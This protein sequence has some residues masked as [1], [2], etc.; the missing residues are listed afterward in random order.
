VAGNTTGGLAKTNSLLLGL[1]LNHQWDDC[2][3]ATTFASSVDDSE[4]VAFVM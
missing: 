4:A 3:I 2:L 1:G